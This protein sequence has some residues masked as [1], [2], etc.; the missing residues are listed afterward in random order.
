MAHEFKNIV[1]KF[2]MAS[3]ANLNSVLATTVPIGGSS[4]RRY[5]GHMLIYED[6]KKLAL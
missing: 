4:N 3:A 2:Q 6:D 1:E 5:V